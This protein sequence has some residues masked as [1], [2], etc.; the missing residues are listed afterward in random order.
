MALD[1]LTDYGDAVILAGVM[2]AR[3]NLGATLKAFSEQFSI[4]FAT[5][6]LSKGIVSERH[7]LALGVYMGAV[8]PQPI[9]NQVESAKPLITLGVLYADLVMGGFTD[10]LNREHVIESCDDHT[11]IGLHTFKD[12]PL[13]AFLP[14]LVDAASKN[15][16]QEGG[17]SHRT[18]DHFFPIPEKRLS[19]EKI[20]ACVSSNLDDFD[21]LLIDPGDCLFASVDILSTSYSLASAYYA[22]MGYAVPAA[23]GAGLA[24]R[25]FRP[26]VLVGDGA[27]LMTALETL[28]SA[29]HGLNSI[30]IVVDNGGYGTQRPMLDGPFNDIPLFKSE[31]L[32]LSFDLGKGFVCV[33]EN[34]FYQ[35]FLE[36]KNSDQL[37][38]IRAC[39]PQHQYSP[40]L[41]RLTNALKKKV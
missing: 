26:I 35:S 10:N 27:F 29:Y 5:T 32:T 34:E 22:S 16:Y 3:R 39:V 28:H 13:W 17:F 36:A 41:V 2:V 21:R 12:V 33:T 40:A 4:P 14:A 38:I 9:V 6:S 20:M 31:L 23:L 19:V 7:P 37:C 1:M 25:R 18:H 24:D 11:N 15:G 8:S 30:I